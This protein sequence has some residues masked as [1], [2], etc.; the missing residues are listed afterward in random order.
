MVLVVI[1]LVLTRLLGGGKFDRVST[2][3]YANLRAYETHIEPPKRPGKIH[4]PTKS[5]Q[6]T[7]KSSL[8]NT[9]RSV[10]LPS[11]TI[12]CH[13]QV[14]INIQTTHEIYKK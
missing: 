11:S 6:E 1:F 8:A 4:L 2:L 12:T 10:I 14:L 13:K 5:P 3:M 7:T 9:I